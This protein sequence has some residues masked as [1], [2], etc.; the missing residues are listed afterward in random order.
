MRTAA[1]GRAGGDRAHRCR[2]DLQ[3]ARPMSRWS[4]SGSQRCSRASRGKSSSSMTI[5]PTARR[6][7]RATLP[8]RD[9][10]VRVI[11]R[12]GRR[13]LSTACVEGVLSSAAPYLRGHGWRPA[14]RRNCA[15]GDAAPSQG[16]EPRYR[17]RQPLHRRRAHGGPRRALPAVGEPG[18][19]AGCPARSPRRSHRSDERLLRH[20][21]RRVRR[22]PCASLS[23]QGFK[24]LLDLF[25][26][27]P[28]PLRFAEVPCRFNA[29][30]HGESKLDT[31]A[32]WE[33]GILVLDKLIGRFVPV[34]FV[35]FSLVS[36]APASSS[37]WRSC[38]C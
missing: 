21:A 10:R 11:R 33:F 17:R 25:A 14:A 5:R 35:I 34:R 12:I 37:I 16:R 9:R 18:R 36:A 20:V 28:R 4:S 15:A 3:R 23:Q 38:G 27:A 19:R 26:S 29:R 1:D 32:A 7:W 22:R 13:G 8:Q 30:Q 24:I 2:A 6:V 31:M